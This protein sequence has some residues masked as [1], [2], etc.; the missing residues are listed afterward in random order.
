[1]I[2]FEQLFIPTC[3]FLKNTD[4]KSPRYSI[5]MKEL[6]IEMK[7]WPEIIPVK[8]IDSSNY[9]VINLSCSQGARTISEAGR[10]HFSWFRNHS[11]PSVVRLF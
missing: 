10:A 5:E 7:H 4:L 9:P 8:V 1:V 11:A 3:W 2:H 6:Q